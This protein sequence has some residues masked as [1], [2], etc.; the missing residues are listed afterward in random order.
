MVTTTLQG[1]AV[2]TRSA[3]RMISCLV[4]VDSFF[5]SNLGAAPIIRV[6]TL[7]FY[8]PCPSPSFAAGDADSW[9]QLDP[10]GLLLSSTIIDTRLERNPLPENLGSSAH[11]L[12]ALLSSV[13]LRLA[14]VRHRVLSANKARPRADLL[15]PGRLYQTDSSGAVLAPT[16]LCIQW[17]YASHLGPRQPN[18]MI[19]WHNICMA[20]VAD[21]DSFEIAAGRDGQESALSALQDIATWAETPAARRACLHAAQTYLCMSCKKA[22]DAASFLSE[23]ALF[24]AALVLG[25][26]LYVSPASLREGSVSGNTK[27]FDILDEVDWTELGDCGFPDVEDSGIPTTAAGDFIKNGGDFLFAGVRHTGGPS[28]ARKVMLEFV[29]LLEEVGKWKVGEFCRILRTL[30]D[31]PVDLDP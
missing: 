20:I 15:I 30:S 8:A 14:D 3:F 29:G 16:L 25:L 19:F 7:R 2:L 18:Q 31:S 9:S 28:S 4:M 12:D 27:C 11:G 26:Y 23:T 5:A 17:T 22:T 13:W 1:T 24:N 10:D 21:V 6:E